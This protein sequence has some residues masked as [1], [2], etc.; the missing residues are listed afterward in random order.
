MTLMGLLLLLVQINRQS[1]GVLA[2]YFSEARD[3]SAAQIGSITSAMYLASTLAQIPTGILFDRF[4]ARLT[5]SGLG[6]L[7]IAGV[8]LFAISETT[9]GL[10]AGRFLMGLGHGGVITGI[11]I[12]AIA[13]TSHE[14]MASVSSLVMGLAGGIGGLL[15]TTPLTLMLTGYGFQTTFMIVA[16]LTAVVTMAIFVFVRDAPTDATVSKRKPENLRQS[17]LGVW[18]IMRDPNMHRLIVMG[19]C[20][21]APFSTIGG[22]WAGP[23]LFDIYQLSQEQAS[24]VL[25]A[26]IVAFNLGTLTYWTHG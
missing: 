5:L 4:G 7:G 10:A 13:W 19:F 16:I 3:L 23:Y 24:Y 1:G 15:A 21:S 12:L 20:F 22:L 17:L 11:Y 26:M 9:T 18:Q 14:R 8:L 6:I 25:F 2:I